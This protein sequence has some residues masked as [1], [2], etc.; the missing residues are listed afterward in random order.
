M[1]DVII[2]KTEKFAPYELTII[3][4]TREHAHA[5][6]M[7]FSEGARYVVGGAKRV[8]QEDVEIWLKSIRSYISE[9]DSGE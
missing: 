4:K 3:A 2:K 8:V 5:L 1:S 7:V 6:N 9:A